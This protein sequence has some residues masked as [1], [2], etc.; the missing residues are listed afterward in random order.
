MSSDM[1]PPGDVHA[2]PQ[3]VVALAAPVA[4]AER[5]SSIDVLRGFAI[6]GIL[7]I[8]IDLF[9]M[10]TSVMQN[11]MVMGGFE[12]LDFAA[13][14]FASVLFS[15]KFMA[16]F[17][18][19]FGAGII[20]LY[21]RSE[22]KGLS[23]RAMFLRRQWWLL[24]F[25]ALHAYFLWYGDILFPY[26]ICG[27]IVYLFRRKS[28]RFLVI[29]G[30][31]VTVVGLAPMAGV[32]AMI[33]WI[34]DQ[35]ASGQ[36]ALDAGETPT[37][38]ERQMMSTWPEMSTAFEPADEDLAEENETMRSG[39]WDIVKRQFPVVLSMHLI[40]YPLFISWRIAGLMLVGMG[41]MKWGVF[42]AAR[43]VR[44]YVWSVALGYGVGIP[45]VWYGSEQMVRHEFDVSYVYTTGW[46]Y[47]YVF[48]LLIVLGH[49]GLV[50]LICKLDL[51]GWIR[52]RLA[53]VGRMALSNY[54]IQS[55]ICT[56]IFYGWGLGYFGVFSR[57]ELWLFVIGIWLVQLFYSPLWLS[58][59]RFGPFEWLWRTLTYKKLQ[60]MQGS[61]NADTAAA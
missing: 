57:A 19:L 33:G 25:G 28:A 17:S 50:M 51:L 30:L 39:Y 40:A 23:M 41:L 36:A 38:L 47:D 59:F 35:A 48:G 15:M 10:S 29:V 42:S 58:R 5:I 14:Q 32:G 12:G 46:P 6:L 3:T 7:V 2:E 45:V 24:L 21:R 44:F 34:R 16:L 54:L 43:S 9:S 8:N 1:I 18:L 20:L 31:I 4:P 56:F 61:A 55:I 49:I 37:D 22:E 52:R 26:A 13:W 11:P 27:M 60:P 53:A